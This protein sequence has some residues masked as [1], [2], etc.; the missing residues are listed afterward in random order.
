[1]TFSARAGE[2]EGWLPPLLEG[3]D[4]QGRGVEGGEDVYFANKLESGD[5]IEKGRKDLRSEEWIMH[6]VGLA[7]P[8]FRILFSSEGRNNNWGLDYRLSGV[9]LIKLR[10]SALTPVLKFEYS[11]ER[12]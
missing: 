3:E 7:P 2:E 11:S 4:G 10:I 9:V 5:W 8:H 1:M 12:K 6:K